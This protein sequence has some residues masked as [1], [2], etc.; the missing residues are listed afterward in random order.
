MRLLIN[1][2]QLDGEVTEKLRMYSANPMQQSPFS[3][4]CY[5]SAIQGIPCI[6]GKLQS[7]LCFRRGPPVVPVL[8][9]KSSTHSQVLFA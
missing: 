4:A 5:S 3:E 7:P 8:I 6:L 9:H 2:S 1:H